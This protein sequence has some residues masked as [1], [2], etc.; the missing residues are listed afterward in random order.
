MANRPGTPR[1]ASHNEFSSLEGEKVSEWTAPLHVI[2][3]FTIPTEVQMVKKVEWYYH[4][5]G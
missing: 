4:R 1:G 5:K 2:P 3:F